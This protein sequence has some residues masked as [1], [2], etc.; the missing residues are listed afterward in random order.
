LPRKIRLKRA[1]TPRGGEVNLPPSLDRPV[2]CR[3][4]PIACLHNP[5][6]ADLPTRAISQALIPTMLS[7]KP[8]RAAP[9]RRGA[10]RKDLLRALLLLP[11]I[12]PFGAMLQRLR[13]R[14]RPRPQALPAD[15]PMGL[16]VAGD[17]VAYRHGD[18][19]VQAWA[20]R[21]T[22]LGCRL[23]RVIDGAVVCPCHGSRFDEQGRVLTGPA[24]KP[25]QPLQVHVAAAGGWTVQAPG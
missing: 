2:R 21:C 23:D 20:A 17:V 3:S 19:R 5:N 10:G 6:L 8:G 12:W 1:Q 16:S 14:N 25:L 22:H 9:R 15:L 18:G 7:A 11:L 24:A 13:V 4:R